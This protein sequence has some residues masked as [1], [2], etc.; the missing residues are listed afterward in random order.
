MTR[1]GRS[2]FSLR[3]A[4]LILLAMLWQSATSEPEHTGRLCIAS[5]TAPN[6]Q[7]K[8]LANPSGGNPDVAYAVKVADRDRIEISHESGIWLK[9]LAIDTRLPVIIYED[10]ERAESFYVQ[11][12][13]GMASKCLFLN[14]LYL[15]W[16]VWDWKRTGPWCDCSKA[17]ENE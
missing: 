11:F 1:S 12:S 14:S 10:G 4:L 15:T 5:V 3:Y 17:A 8:S 9:G 2:R 13:E 6:D 7:T 16:Q